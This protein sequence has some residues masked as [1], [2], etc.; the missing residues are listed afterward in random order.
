MQRCECNHQKLWSCVLTS[1]MIDRWIDRTKKKLLQ[2]CNM[3]LCPVSYILIRFISRRWSASNLFIWPPESPIHYTY[4][5]KTANLTGYAICKLK[6]LY[7]TG[8]TGASQ[9]ILQCTVCGIVARTN[10]TWDVLL[11]T[12]LNKWN[13]S[14]YL[15]QFC[16]FF[17]CSKLSCKAGLC[18]KT[19]V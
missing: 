5:K 14:Y 13:P 4:R 15:P 3:A 10:R 7:T 16:S 17:L 11:L 1:L 18:T 12:L 8:P 19:Q 9:H 6:I 2:M